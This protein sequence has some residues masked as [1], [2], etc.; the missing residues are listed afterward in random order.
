[1][2]QKGYTRKQVLKG[3]AAA[4]LGTSL[5]LPFANREARALSRTVAVGVYPSGNGPL[6]RDYSGLDAYIDLA[7]GVQPKIVS[8]FSPWVSGDGIDLYPGI[9]TW[10]LFYDRYPDSVI[11]WGWE[12]FGV[13]LDEIN[14]GAHDAYIDEVARRITAV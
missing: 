3:G 9:D 12:P 8:V 7:G 11:M 5:A 6:Y 10:R 13:T 2:G 14:S 1:M 4:L